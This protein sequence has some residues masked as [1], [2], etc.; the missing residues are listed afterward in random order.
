VVEGSEDYEVFVQISKGKVVEHS[1]DC[2]Y[3]WGDVCKH[4]VVVLYY[5]RDIEIGEEGSD[6]EAV[7]SQLKTIIDDI[8]EQDLRDYVLFY[9]SRNRQFREDFTEEFG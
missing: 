4:I 7:T 3:D 2:P 6:N 5:I 9:A 1:C 8:S